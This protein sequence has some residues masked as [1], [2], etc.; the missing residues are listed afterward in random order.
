MQQED[1]KHDIDNIAKRRY[2]TTINLVVIAILAALG[3]V[4]SSMLDLFKPLFKAS[5]IPFFQIFGGYH[6]IWMALAYGLTGKYGASTFTAA[7]KGIL[8]FM[9]WDPFF[10]PWVLLLN[11]AEGIMID[12]GFYL[13]HH[14]NHERRRWVATGMLGNVAQPFI[15]Y[16]I[17]FYYLGQPVLDAFIM[18]A[19]MALA[20]AS[21][22]LITGLLGFHVNTVLQR[23][24]VRA[25]ISTR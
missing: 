16:S 23:V 5:P 1:S 14:F 24:D 18:L 2:F 8:E 22:A 13:F 9:F 20:V 21:G 19:A 15:S 12:V 7:I 17:V 25:F 6:L 11:L 10:G 3:N 4:I